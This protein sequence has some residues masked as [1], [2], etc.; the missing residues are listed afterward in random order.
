MRR[1]VPATV[2]VL[3]AVALI[4]SGQAA[5]AAG[6]PFGNSAT[7]TVFNPNPVQEL[8]LENLPDSKDSDDPVF[9][10]AYH[11]KTLT[12]LDASG[13]LTGAYVRVKSNTGKAAVAVDGAF[14]DWHRNVDQFEQ[15][16]GYYWVTTAQ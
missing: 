14:P 9:A 5:R 7:G 3:A 13:T 8:G 1:I 4:T 6:T 15:V 12:D 11:R 16:M 2:A 10:P